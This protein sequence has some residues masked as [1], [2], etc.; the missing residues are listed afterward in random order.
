M[1]EC[2]V[3]GG[4]TVRAQLGVK[5]PLFLLGLCLVWRHTGT[6]GIW[7]TRKLYAAAHAHFMLAKQCVYRDKRNY[8][9]RTFPYILSI[10]NFFRH[11]CQIIL[12]IYTSHN[13][14]IFLDVHENMAALTGL[15]K[16]IERRPAD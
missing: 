8:T 9:V 7:L 3:C 12:K 10:S 13:R 16:W 4:S 1:D 2:F 11:A 6:W 15:A 14:N 5:E